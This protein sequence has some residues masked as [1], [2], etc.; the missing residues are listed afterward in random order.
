MKTFA[1]T[2]LAALTMV[3]GSASADVIHPATGL[4]FNGVVDRTFTDLG[5]G[6]KVLDMGGIVHNNTQGSVWNRIIEL[7]VGAGDFGVGAIGWDLWA[8]TPDPALLSTARIAITNS[9]GDGV[10]LTPF[11]DW[12]D[13]GEQ[14]GYHASGYI[15]ISD[16]AL[17]FPVLDGEITIEMFLT[18][19]PIAGPEVTYLQ[20]ST[21]TVEVVPAPGAFALLGMGGL[22]ATRRRRS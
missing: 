20:G 9:A 19:N 18:S 8:T 6:A 16:L 12:V 21:L 5:E 17:G 10:I 14:E 22:A 1:I 4:G 2:A 11:T 15:N 13:R 7:D 3:A